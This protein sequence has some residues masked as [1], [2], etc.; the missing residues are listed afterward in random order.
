MSENALGY[1]L[2]RAG[3]HHTHCPHGF[4]ASFSSIMSERHP[5]DH[6]AIEAALA[7]RV[8]GVR[9]R[10]MRAPFLQRRR[11]LACEWADLIL[12]GGKDAKSLL[13][14]PRR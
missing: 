11:E 10:Y 12:A 1:L 13:L 3:Y 14:G 8:D 5:A 9:G 6:D 2:N 7:H 4:R